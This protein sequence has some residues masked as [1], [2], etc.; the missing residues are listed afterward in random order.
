MPIGNS[1]YDVARSTAT[2]AAGNVYVGGRFS[3][4]VDFDPSANT[5]NLV[6]A[7]G[8]DIFLAKYDASGNYLWAFNWGDD[9]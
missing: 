8:S 9:H 3:G 4:T 5:A 1:S 7:N 2:D 6:S